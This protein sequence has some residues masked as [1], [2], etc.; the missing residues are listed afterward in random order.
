MT[1]KCEPEHHLVK[2][3]LTLLRKLGNN[4][5]LHKLILEPTRDM[6]EE[7]SLEVNSQI[8]M[9]QLFK[10]IKTSN[11]LEMLSLGCIEELTENM[12]NLLDLLRRHQSDHLTHL[13]LAS[14]KED[15]DH[16]DV[17]E[18]DCSLF[19][20]FSKLSV[21]TIDYDHLC[22]ELLLALNSGIMERIVIHVHNWDAIYDHMYGASDDSWKEFTEKK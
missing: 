18:I 9:Q 2:E 10:I 22:D 15:P 1:I 7:S 12:S 13:S 17:L 19:N 4:R 16:Y 20:S 8:M 5:Q 6:F 11:K 14:V 21:L 3:V